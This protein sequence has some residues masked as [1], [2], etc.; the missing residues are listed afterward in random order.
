MF[1][2]ILL[3]NKRKNRYSY[4]ANL[5]TTVLFYVILFSVQLFLFYLFSSNHSFTWFTFKIK[6]EFHLYR[7]S[8]SF[9]CFYIKLR[10]FAI[11][12]SLFYFMPFL[13]YNFVF[14]LNFCI[15]IFQLFIFCINI[16]FYPFINRPFFAHWF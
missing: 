14:T 2:F 10:L 13:Y 7:I 6:Y 5:H 8:F 15:I 3:Q 12:N 4:A 9:C 16:S 1:L 11:I